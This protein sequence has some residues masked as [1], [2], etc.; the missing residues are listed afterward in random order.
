LPYAAARLDRRGLS[1]DDSHVKRFLAAGLL[2]VGSQAVAG[3]LGAQSDAIECGPTMRAATIDQMKVA[4]RDANAGVRRHLGGS[5][6]EAGSLKDAMQ[7]AVATGSALESASLLA[8]IREQ[9]VYGGDKVAVNA[10]LSSS[11]FTA[12]QEA[13]KAFQYINPALAK[14]TS[15]GI[16]ADAARMRDAI[17]AVIRV[18]GNCRP[19]RQGA[20][21]N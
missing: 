6:Q 17:E 9:M 10:R 15:P 13:E 7:A 3:L 19:P 20:P 4:V 5:N 21:G 18:L 8:A 14:I 16:A 11:L 12:R 1:A 2:L